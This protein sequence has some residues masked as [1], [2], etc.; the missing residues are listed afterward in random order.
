MTDP[1]PNIRHSNSKEFIL[2]SNAFTRLLEGLCMKPSFTADARRTRGKTTATEGLSDPALKVHLDSLL[3]ELDHAQPKKLDVQYEVSTSLLDSV[4]I[5]IE[6]A[7]A[8]PWD[9]SPLGKPRRTLDAGYARI[10]WVCVSR[11]TPPG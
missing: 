4:K 9:W 7:Q 1:S 5:W 2:S 8:I 3:S 6:D 10:S 11:L